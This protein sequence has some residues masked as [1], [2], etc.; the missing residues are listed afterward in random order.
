M[1]HDGN[2]LGKPTSL[3]KRSKKEIE[4]AGRK[5]NNCKPLT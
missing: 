4:E 5:E 3:R 1:G 2:T